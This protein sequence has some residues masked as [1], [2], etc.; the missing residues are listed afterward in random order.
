MTPTEILTGE[1]AGFG[2]VQGL[3]GRVLRRFTVTLKGVWSDEHRALHLDETYVYVGREGEE[4]R[5][6]WVL[7]TDEEGFV[8]GYDAHQ[9]AR[10]RGRQDGQDVRVVFD[11]PVRPGGRMEPRQI[12][13]LV[14]ISPTQLMMVGRV[15]ILGV[16]IAT[17]HTALT[18]HA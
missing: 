2:C 12:V 13:R 9:A 16:P 17:M 15:V 10:L 5:R 1:I 3:T 18:K 6:S 8:L 14:Q 4:F 7:H 11:R